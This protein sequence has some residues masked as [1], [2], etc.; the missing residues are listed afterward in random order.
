[1]KSKQDA[2]ES[3]VFRPYF[4]TYILSLK[5]PGS[6]ETPP[7]ITKK[8]TNTA[9][10]IAAMAASFAPN[11][12]SNTPVQN[13]QSTSATSKGWLISE[14]IS[15]SVQSLKRKNQITI[16]KVFT[17]VTF[18]FKGCLISECFHFGSNLLLKGAK[19]FL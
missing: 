4:N 14:G 8:A 10:G 13:Q 11:S 15:K 7:Q 18:R 16:P 3:E 12:N 17:L 2:P 5:K 9:L 1:M 6:S 19:S